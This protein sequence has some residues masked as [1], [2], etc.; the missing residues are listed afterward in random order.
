MLRVTIELLPGGRECDKRVIATAN[1]A[2]LGD[3]ALSD[4]KV[5]LKETP[6]GVVGEPAF[7]YKYPRWSS[8]VW[9]LTSRC[10]AAALTQGREEL[11]PRPVQLEVK[12]RTNDAGHRYV[13]LD[14]IPEPT[15]TFFDQSLAGSA[16]PDHGRAYAHDWF[17]FLCGK[18]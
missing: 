16:I 6:F 4:Y 17:N 3:G 2:R 18:R 13:R 8:S 14:E 15:R 12:V 10:I 1:I 9:D 11:P 7:V 5:V